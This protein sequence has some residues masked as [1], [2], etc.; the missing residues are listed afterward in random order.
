M[1]ECSRCEGEGR[2]RKGK[3]YFVKVRTWVRGEKR[4]V[5]FALRQQQRSRSSGGQDKEGKRKKPKSK[6]KVKSERVPT[7]LLK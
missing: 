3:T 1:N 2:A 5:T 6:R 7:H 4:G